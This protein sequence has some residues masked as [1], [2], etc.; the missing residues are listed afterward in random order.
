MNKQKRN[1]TQ[2]SKYVVWLPVI[3]VL[4]LFALVESID[5]YKDITSASWPSTTG[6]VFFVNVPAPKSYSIP[7][8]GPIFHPLRDKQVRFNYVVEG[9]SYESE[10]MSFGF[11]FSENIEPIKTIEPNHALAKVYY[12]ISKPEEAVLVPGP[13]I[14]N[15]CLVLV[16]ILVI[17][18]ILRKENIEAQHL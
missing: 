14:P 12:N 3:A 10:N 1:N 16:P 17:I 18:W 9:K 6:D 7:E 13:K 11:T 5:L 2:S 4:A 8:W 15:I